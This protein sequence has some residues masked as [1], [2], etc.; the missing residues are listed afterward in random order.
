MKKSLLALFIVMAMI[1]S[2]IPA[3]VA[4]ASEMSESGIVA[5]DQDSYIVEFVTFPGTAVASLTL[6][7]IGTIARPA[8]DPTRR[9]YAF[10]GWYTD[11][12]FST[13][14]NFATQQVTQP[15]TRIY[16]RWEYVGAIIAQ[17][18]TPAALSWHA[19]LNT[20]HY[21]HGWANVDSG[22]GDNLVQY[23]E[24]FIRFNLSYDDVYAI[25][26]DATF[27]AVFAAN[28]NAHVAGIQFRLLAN[29][30]ERLHYFATQPQIGGNQPWLGGTTLA[31]TDLNYRMPGAGSLSGNFTSEQS[32]APS[33][34]LPHGWSPQE[35]DVTDL[36]IDYFDSEY[37]I[38]ND[39][40][41]IGFT[42]VIE[43]RM[44]GSNG[45]VQMNE[46][47]LVITSH[48]ADDRPAEEFVIGEAETY[49]DADGFRAV[50]IEL[51][52]IVETDTLTVGFASAGN[53]ATV[54]NAHIVRHSDNIS[55]RIPWIVGNDD[56]YQIIVTARNAI[57]EFLVS[58]DGVGH[59]EP[60][61]ELNTAL[62]R[63]IFNA[64]G[65]NPV[66]EPRFV[67]ANSL[68]GVSPTP[69]RSGYDFAGWFTNSAA[70]YTLNTDYEW[71]FAV[72]IIGDVL[73][74]T[75]Y[76]GWED[77]LPVQ[78][79]PINTTYANPIWHNRLATGY[80]HGWGGVDS[81]WDGNAAIYAESFVRFNLSTAEIQAARNDPNFFAVFVADAN[82]HSAGAQ[83]RVL[84]NPG[85][86]LHYFAQIENPPN[87]TQP[88]LS[89]A[90]MIAAG[91]N[92]RRFYDGA[93]SVTDNFTPAQSSL[94]S[95]PFYSWM[96]H[97]ID[98]TALLVDYFTS[99]YVVDNGLTGIGFTIVLENQMP[100][101]GR[102]QMMDIRLVTSLY[103][104][105]RP[106]GYVEVDVVE[107][108]GYIT[109]TTDGANRYDSVE[110]TFETSGETVV[111]TFDYNENEPFVVF[112]PWISGTDGE[113]DIIVRVLN[114]G[115]KELVSCETSMTLAAIP[116]LISNV[117]ASDGANA[118][119]VIALY[120]ANNRF[121]G[122]YI[123]PPVTVMNGQAIVM[124]PVSFEIPSGYSAKVMMFDDFATLRPLLPAPY[125]II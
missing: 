52:G 3:N 75:L 46:M 65:G 89:S 124:V 55:M 54:S 94:P 93:V 110:V 68:L 114:W 99:Q 88:W 111:L 23:A 11:N 6:S 27:S 115:G 22:F 48:F 79:T 20:T 59:N 8:N 62:R 19:R 58:N 37:V 117:N 13:L 112:V 61:I 106:D 72:D 82:A 71:D 34:V 42:V 9:M 64:T 73:T 21:N 78:F 105:F 108:D 87:A 63:V 86:R 31:G 57:G 113:F 95:E 43:E 118:Q 14:W 7:A 29:P 77:T 91:L 47:R 98:V 45:R 50:S 103:E 116:I 121:A 85:E 44:T 30:G 96:L 123:T 53:T 69:S 38:N 109:I 24:S 107:G 36:L 67:A 84:A 104:D 49:V 10:A 90:A 1:A 32:S 122:S 97:E 16:A 25:R 81:R 33:A 60:P 4:A 5:F 70:A 76:A 18:I 92:Y 102:L 74:T 35:I 101:V 66:P 125:E 12:T 26:N 40:T 39:L 17:T 15:L 80:A 41:D 51:E 120:N 100:G 2:I 56:N 119:A 28:A 83:F